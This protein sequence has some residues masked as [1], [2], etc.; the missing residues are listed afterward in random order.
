MTDFNMEQTVN[1]FATAMG[2][3]ATMG[4]LFREAVDYVIETRDTTVILRMIQRAEKRGDK[5]AASLVRSTF[6]KVFVGAKVNTKAGNIIG[7]KIAGS[8]ISNW[9][10]SALHALADD[11][12]SMRGPKWKAAFTTEKETPAFDLQAFVARALK[13][14]PEVSKAVFAAAFQ[15]A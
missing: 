9:A 6:G 12:V 4:K 15:A 13:A 8:D 7:I 14:H 11:K 3:G 1:A 5:A 2:N 10:L